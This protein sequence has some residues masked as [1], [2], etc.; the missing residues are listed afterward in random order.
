M[1]HSWYLPGLRLIAY[2]FGVQLSLMPAV[3]HGLISIT[4]T[5]TD[6]LFQN[7]K[8]FEVYESHRWVV[9]EL[10]SILIPLATSRDGVEV[11]KHATKPIYG[12]QFHPEMFPDK[13]AGHIIFANLL[14]EINTERS[15]VNSRRV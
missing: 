7:I 6:P 1:P 9:K 14:K 10:P 13:T 5:S 3:E 4:P 2:A 8:N 11:F 12:F 15:L